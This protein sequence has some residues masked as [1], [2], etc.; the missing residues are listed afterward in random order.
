MGLID[1]GACNFIRVIRN[2]KHSHFFT[3]CPKAPGPFVARSQSLAPKAQTLPQ[4]A[5]DPLRGLR[6][7]CKSQRSFLCPPAAGVPLPALRGSDASLGGFWC[8]RV[9]ACF[10]SALSWSLA[11]RDLF[12]HDDFAWYHYPNRW[13]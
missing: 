3:A 7:V 4:K 10:L 1:K 11:S 5:H 12:A 9:C 13:L 8:V 6:V 2:W